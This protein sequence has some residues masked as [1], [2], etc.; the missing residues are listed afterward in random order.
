MLC[1][2]L[3]MTLSNCRGDHYK[4]FTVY[5]Y[6]DSHKQVTQTSQAVTIMLINTVWFSALGLAFLIPKLLV[7]QKCCND[8]I[9]NFM[10]I[11][12]RKNDLGK[13]ATLVNFTYLMLPFKLIPLQIYTQTVQHEH[14]DL[15]LLNELH[16][17]LNYK[18]GVTRVPNGMSNIIG[19]TYYRS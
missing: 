15:T 4:A 9:F 2:Y 5:M 14:I 11:K 19:H 1:C 16:G 3:Y 13:I 17:P 6:N 10:F 7:T 8:F 12:A 18:I